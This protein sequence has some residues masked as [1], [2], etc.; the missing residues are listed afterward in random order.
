MLV[1]PEGSAALRLHKGKDVENRLIR[2]SFKPTPSGGR[3][4]RGST[5]YGE[6]DCVWDESGN[7]V[8]S[9][10]VMWEPEDRS[11]Y[12]TKHWGRVVSG[13]SVKTKNTSAPCQYRGE[14]TGQKARCKSCQGNILVKVF[15]CIKH[16]TCT[17]MKRMDGHAC[18][19]ACSD[20]NPVADRER[21]PDDGAEN[22]ARNL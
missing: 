19:V 13:L 9:D 17:I 3:R 11:K 22:V 20:Y 6:F 4:A 16:G 5:P 8:R 7:I 12:E 21:T 18:C 1:P 14:P 2:Q 15:G 10:L